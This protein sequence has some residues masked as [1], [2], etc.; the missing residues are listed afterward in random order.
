[1]HNT[2]RFL[3]FI[4]LCVL[5]GILIALASN[6]FTMFVCYELLT[7]ATILLIAHEL[8][9]KVSSVNKQEYRVWFNGKL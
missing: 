9:E 1:M 8:S 5:F 4:N 3:F 6:L 7:L 2:S